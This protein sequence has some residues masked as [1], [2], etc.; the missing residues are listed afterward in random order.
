[1]DQSAL[2]T[3]LP[4]N[5]LTVLSAIVLLT[6]LVSF[7]LISISSAK[8]ERTA[9]WLGTALLF[10][11]TI[12]SLIVFSQVLNAGAAH[13]R[14]VWFHLS[15][16]L[17][18]TY[19]LK[20][21]F[22]AAG[23]LVVVCLVSFLVHL[24]STQYMKGDEGY[25]R[26]FAFLGLFTFSMLG[27]V[28]CDNLLF[29][30]IFWELVGLSSYLLIGHWY[31]KESASKAAQKAFIVNRIGDA[32]FIIG[33]AILWSQ[34]KTLDLELLE[35]LMSSSTIENG[36]WVSTTG[37]SISLEWLTVSGIC[38]FMGA[39]G[40]SAQFPLQIWLPDAMEGPTPVSALI[41][42]ATMVA[43]GVFLLARVFTL[44][45]I[46]AMMVIAF[47]GATTAFM[48]AIAA[49]TQNDIKKVLAYS[50]ISQ[51]G[52][53]LM[54]MGVGAYDAALFHL[55]THAFFKAC[56]FLGAGSVIHALHKYAHDNH[57]DFDHQDMRNMGGIR[58]WMPYTF[59]TYIVASLALVGVPFFS[60][61]LSKDAIL[62]G[63]Y[64]LGV[65]EGGNNP[66]Y[67]LIPLL[68]FVSVILT[69]LYMARQL[70]LVFLGD[71]RLE[72]T[73]E[74]LNAKLKESPWVMRSALIILS[75]LS[76]G[77]V[78][79]INPF[80]STGSWLLDLI[81]TPQ[82]LSP[83]FPSNWQTRLAG[84][85]VAG[86]TS[87][88]MISIAM[89]VIGVAYAWFKFKPGGLYSQ[90]YAIMKE[91]DSTLYQLSNK[92]WLLNELYTSIITR[93]TLYLSFI[94]AKIETL[95]IDRAVNW[96]GIGYVIIANV[97][98]WIDRHLVDGFVNFSVFFAG[99]IGVLTKSV[100]GGKVQSYIAVA[101]LGLLIIIFSLL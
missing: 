39:V 87:V 38:L 23:M 44:L 100:Q 90:V 35:L 101:I 67:F 27:I 69:A 32:G 57:L 37:S 88:S 56:L 51:L 83:D 97:V 89:V 25:K 26:Y 77:I 6:P 53:M 99:R 76:L 3:I 24:Y 28:L 95:I 11:S 30:F 41:H 59:I 68:G 12:L 91:S 58:K 61:F 49:L 19:G 73:G 8:V 7:V 63:A 65:I 21:D 94:M 36:N 72:S 78:W 62:S 40:K 55:L 86:H 34:F 70:L 22:I 15:S 54:G 92:N 80:S 31:S 9:S 33:L 29:I 85:A 10:L 82:I 46:D 64:A 16:E 13:S 81:E 60:G 1:M 66:V 43:A 18:V 84:A 93:P 14:F 17:F 50:T 74:T 4:W 45:N 71:F 42:A 96:L 2:N 75:L 5:S 79:S 20:I 52:Y 47:V 48:G 98:G